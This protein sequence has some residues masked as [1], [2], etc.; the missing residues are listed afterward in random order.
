MAL[1]KWNCSVYFYW[2]REKINEITIIA[3]LFCNRFCEREIKNH[4]RF[5]LSSYVM[6][7]IWAICFYRHLPKA[8]LS[9]CNKF[10]FWENI[11]QNTSFMCLVKTS[12]LT[13]TFHFLISFIFILYFLREKNDMKIL[14][15]SLIL[16]YF[17]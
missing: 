3:R 8:L 4:F 14:F 1:F 16:S 10:H 15:I 9:S 6:L 2:C 11:V 12:P 5:H 7:A 17:P 13:V